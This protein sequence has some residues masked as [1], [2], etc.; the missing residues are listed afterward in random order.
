MILPNF[1]VLIISNWIISVWF[2]Q[3]TSNQSVQSLVKE[4]DIYYS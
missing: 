3:M 4:D 1:I 2:K